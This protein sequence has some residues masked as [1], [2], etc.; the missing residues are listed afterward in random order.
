MSKWN[1]RQNTEQ[2]LPNVESV[3]TPEE[4]ESQLLRVRN[5]LLTSHNY[6][7]LYVQIGPTEQV[8]LDRYLAF[9]SNT[10]SAL[11]L[12]ALLYLSVL[13]DTDTKTAGLPTLI[14]TAERDRDN[15][16]RYSKPEELRSTRRKLNA[17]P[18]ERERLKTVRDKHL[19][20]LDLSAEAVGFT[21]GEYDCQFVD[22]EAVIKDLYWFFGR[23]G[24]TAESMHQRNEED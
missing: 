8:L 16:A 24:Y 17:H 6:M 22:A 20:H 19:V 11:R 1:F 14:R 12:M 15:L 3:V 23:M 18:M 5:T 4:Y 2:I 21:K 13:F 10:E 9:F 7:S